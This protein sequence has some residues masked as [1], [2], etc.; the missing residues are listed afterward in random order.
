[1]KM[2][3]FTFY[4]YVYTDKDY[5]FARKSYDRVENQAYSIGLAQERKMIY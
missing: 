5:S 1:M 3:Y 2:K 4:Q